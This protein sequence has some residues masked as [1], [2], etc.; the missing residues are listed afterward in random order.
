[1]YIKKDLNRVQSRSN[2]LLYTILVVIIFGKKLE[3]QVSVDDLINNGNI[4]TLIMGY[5]KQKPDHKKK[6]YQEF[7]LRDNLEELSSIGIPPVVLRDYDHWD[8]FLENGHLHWH[9]DSTGFGFEQLSVPQLEKLL[10]FLRKQYSDDQHPSPLFGWLIVRK[11][12]EM[13]NRYH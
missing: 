2:P 13:V 3:H 7:W 1:M 10:A 5:R 12:L 8:D 4:P 9:E 11:R 6:R